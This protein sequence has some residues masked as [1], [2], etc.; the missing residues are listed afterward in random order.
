L[1][2]LLASNAMAQLDPT[3][4]DTGH[5]YLLEDVSGSQAQDD[6]ANN[7]TGTIVGD[8]QVVDGLKGN[9]LQFDGVDDGVQIPDSDFINVNAGPWPNRTVVAMFKCDDVDKSDKQTVFEEGGTTRGLAIYVFEGEVYGAG[10]NRSEYNWDGAWLSTP[11]ESGNWYGV[12]I[13]IRDGAEAVEDDKFE[14]WVNGQLIGKAPGGQL[15]NHGDDAD[16]Q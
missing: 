10:W 12:A 4:V 2:L 15:H 9:A 8:P 1:L 6:S 5:I 13:V 14:M 7:N 16:S 11:I 3:A